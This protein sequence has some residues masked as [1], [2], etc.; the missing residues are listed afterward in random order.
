MVNTKV[1]SR[2]I[3]WKVMA[4]SFGMMVK[5]MKDFGKRIK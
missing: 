2:I 5:N 3:F 1:N 4:I